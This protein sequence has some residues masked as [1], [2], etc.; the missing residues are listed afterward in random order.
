MK[1]KKKRIFKKRYILFFIISIILLVL[2]GV[3]I[4]PN[5]LVVQKYKVENSKLRGIRAV[6]A[7]DFHIKPYQENRLKY[8]VKK[9]NAQNPD[10][11]F[12][13][14]D[15][16]NMHEDKASFPIAQIAE[17][18][19]EI[20][21]AKKIY[22]V[23]GNHDYYKDG[24]KIKKEL[25]LKGITVLENRSVYTRVKD[26]LICIAGIEDLITGFPNLN[27]ALRFSVSPTILLSHQPDIFYKVPESVDLILAGHTHGGQINIPFYGSVIVPSKYG[28]RFSKGF[29]KENGR[30]MIVTKGIGTSIIPVRF[31]SFPEIVVIDFI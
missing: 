31:D 27:K 16:V 9:I 14:G 4:E 21:P 25:S 13:I 8:V 18:L 7:G 20:R 10:I 24:R 12:L 28:T 26:K 19:A 1:Q 5:I 29:F 22:T 2:W 17:R 30:R 23:L 3:L 6:L 15:Y 11:V